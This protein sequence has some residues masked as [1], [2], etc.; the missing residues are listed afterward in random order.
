MCLVDY[1]LIVTCRATNLN[2]LTDTITWTITRNIEGRQSDS[3]SRMI[4]AHGQRTITPITLN[5]NTFIFT[6]KTDF[7]SDTNLVT[8]TSNV[9]VIVT[10]YLNGTV[11]RCSTL[12]ANS[13][14]VF[15]TTTIYV[16]GNNSNSNG[17]FNLNFTAFTLS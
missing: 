1:H 9:S 6:N 2:V 3:R 7:N 14:V 16:I 10:D 8:L 12:D 5:M 15:D 13:S 4:S 17:K 11:I